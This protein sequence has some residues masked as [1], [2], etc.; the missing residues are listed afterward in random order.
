MGFVVR[1]ANSA[2]QSAP[3]V[4]SD[5]SRNGVMDPPL[6]LSATRA[7]MGSG[8]LPLSVGVMVVCLPAS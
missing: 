2:P 3:P 1:V 7:V 5:S 6:V 8:G 4:I